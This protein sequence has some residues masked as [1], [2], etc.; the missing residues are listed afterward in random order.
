[1]TGAVVRSVAAALA[2]AGCTGEAIPDVAA[3]VRAS[4]TE[5]RLA[6][7]EARIGTVVPPA[8]DVDAVADRLWA[9]ARDSGIAGVPGPAGAMGPPGPT[10]AAGPIGPAGPAGA[11]GPVGPRGEA[12]PRG[13][14]G[15]Q[16]VQGL[17]GPQGIQG[18]QGVEG[19][20]GAPGPAGSYAAKRDVMRREARV[21]I[22]PGLVATAVVT[23]EKPIDLVVAG[24]CAAEPIWMAQLIVARPFAVGDAA[25]AAGWRCDYKN[26]SPSTTIEATAEIFCVRGRD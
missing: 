5:R 6:A 21:A 16:G 7:L 24:G 14:E 25:A 13:E 2:L 11:M 10:G 17:Q 19:P 1:M 20:R 12:G 3:R 8:I 22:G 15:P 26:T 4:D 23:C 9:T 18:A